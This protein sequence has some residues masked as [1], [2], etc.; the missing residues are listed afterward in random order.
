MNSSNL[1]KILS[2]IKRGDLRLLDL[3][4]QNEHEFPKGV[5]PEYLDRRWAEIIIS[6]GDVKSVEWLIF[7]LGRDEVSNYSAR[8]GTADLPLVHAALSRDDAH[9]YDVLVIVLNAGGDPNARGLNDYT[10]GH[11]AVIDNDCDAL[12]IL[13]KFGADFEL[14]TRIDEYATPLEEAKIIV[15]ENDAIHLLESWGKEKLGDS[16]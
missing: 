1:S 13:S 3:K 4:K 5:C 15:Q 8:K 10:P 6:E 14:K 9:K 2:A 16:S 12:E 11:Q 7:K